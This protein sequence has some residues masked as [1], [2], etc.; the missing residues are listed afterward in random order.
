MNT[1]FLNHKKGTKVERK[2][3]RGNEPI[4]VII[5]YMEMSKGNSL[6]SYLK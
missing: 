5:L 6:H 3:N 1:E 2:K 4:Q